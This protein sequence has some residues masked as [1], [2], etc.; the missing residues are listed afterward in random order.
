MS[1]VLIWLR[2]IE[3]GQMFETQIK[4][5]MHEINMISLGKFANQYKLKIISW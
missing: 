2:Y 1:G 3:Q 5:K 4:F